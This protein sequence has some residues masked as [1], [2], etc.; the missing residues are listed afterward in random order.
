MSYWPL[1]V[2]E[3]SAVAINTIVVATCTSRSTDPSRRLRR[4]GRG[5]CRS[6]GRRARAPRPAARCRPRRRRRCGRTAAAPRRRTRRWRPRP[7]RVVAIV[8]A[9][10]QLGSSTPRAAGRRADR[11]GRTTSPS[12][13]WR[14]RPA[15][16]RG[17]R[18]SSC[19]S[20][21]RAPASCTRGAVDRQ[22]EAAMRH[23]QLVQ[24]MGDAELAVRGDRDRLHHHMGTQQVEAHS[25]TCA[26]AH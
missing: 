14:T 26:S 20:A 10:Q 19:R 16:R 2:L 24:R 17:R 6:R 3:C 5:N 4:Q 22:G 9:R 25:W 7:E 23:Q 18:P 13:P 21:R 12:R 15:H 8:I 1:L 11:T